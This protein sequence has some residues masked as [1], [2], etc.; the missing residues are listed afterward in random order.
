MLNR[1]SA[2][3][4]VGSAG[5]ILLA[6]VSAAAQTTVV[7]TS[8]AQA[9]PPNFVQLG[10]SRERVARVDEVL[11]DQLSR[12]RWPGSV[13]LIA[14][15]GEIVHFSA[16]GALDGKRDR[17]MQ[18]DSIFRIFSMTK[19]IVTVATMML[20]ERGVLNLEDAIEAH[21]P[22]LKDLK[23]Y[24]VPG[25]D[26]I[27]TPVSL[28][29]S[30]MV[31]DL[32]RHSAGF[33]YSFSGLRSKDVADAYVKQ[34]VETFKQ[35]YSPEEVL[36]RLASIPLAFQPGQNF[37]YGISTDILGILLE[38][39]TMKRLDVLV[40]EM[41]L[42]PLGMRDTG[43]TVPED[44]RARLADAF[45]ADPM[46][47]S[48]WNWARVEKDPAARM[49]L[50]GA[51]MVSTAE[52]YF[53]FAQMMVNGGVLGDVRLLSAK[54]VEYMLTD[55]I[56]D[57]AGSPAGIAG[58]GYRFGLGFAIR[59]QLGSAFTPGSLGDANWS[60]IGGTAFTVDPKEQI[61]GV[62]MVQAPSHRVVARNMF[63][64]LIYSTIVK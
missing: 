33:T 50:A 40:D 63:K 46:K 9:S 19:P 43:F 12:N 52:D 51:G 23:V 34:D 53:K 35:D 39:L 55:H 1:A 42:R 16:H 28:R 37:E 29:R 20:V 3:L 25:A 60:G 48:L 10:V 57:M 22:E 61:V 13:T 44:K 32:L 36:K 26:G 17:P 21:L 62:I 11:A 14:R 49:R 15:R 30:I 2:K 59:T 41:V 54:T 56:A 7:Q 8:G 45:D 24:A 38:R 47:A 18:K 58:P 5:W 27:S 6:A 64:N 31:Q 4:C